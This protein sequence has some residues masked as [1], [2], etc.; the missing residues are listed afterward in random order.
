MKR[1]P[2]FKGSLSTGLGIL[3][4]GLRLTRLD[5]LL[6]TA[7]NRITGNQYIR[8][9]N[10][11]DTPSCFA[12]GFEKQ[13]LYYQKHFTSVDRGDLDSFFAN[14][15]W[16]REKPGLIISFDD[17]LRSNYDVALPLLEKYGFTGWF[18][19]PSGFADIPQTEQVAWGKAHQIKADNHDYAD[20][21]VAMSWPEICDLATRHVVGCHSHNHRRLSALKTPDEHTMEIITSK[22]LFE[23]KIG[24]CDIFCWVGGERSSYSAEAAD[25]I[26]AAGYRYSFMTN[27]APIRPT[28]NRLQLQRTNVEAHW[29]VET[30]PFQMS[31]VLDVM[32]FRK[33]RAVNALTR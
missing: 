17:G 6:L 31:G 19:I 27:C 29:P 20:G 16:P 13:L 1:H 4:W 15:K 2:G 23:Q 5:T 28:T 30:L 12:P 21:R 22:K 3:A 11:H 14:G 8:V 24:R 32:Y 33:R 7:Y 18:F 25:S 9:V 26:R 10:Y